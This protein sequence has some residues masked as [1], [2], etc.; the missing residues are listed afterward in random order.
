MGIKDGTS[1]KPAWTTDEIAYKVIETDTPGY[2]RMTSEAS[3][4]GQQFSQ[5]TV[6]YDSLALA[7]SQMT[8]GSLLVVSL[9][10][11]PTASNLRKTIE[12]RGLQE[13]DYRLFRPTFDEHGR[14]YPRNKRPLVLQRI[15]AKQ[16]RT[17]QPF[18]AL[19]EHV[20]KE[21]EQRGTTYNFAQPE[22][23]VSP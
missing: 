7:Y 15:T 9:P 12:T 19:A 18:T 3:G 5:S 4:R 16:M 8:P 2:A 20:A 17:V 1:A 23:P 6:I 10:N 14:R 13:E 21:A 11:R 22:N